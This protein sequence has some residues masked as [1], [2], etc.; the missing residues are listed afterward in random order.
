MDR[1]RPPRPLLPVLGG[2]TAIVVILVGVHLAAPFL[3]PLLFALYFSVL[4]APVH[5]WLQRR[6]LAKGVA[7]LL[8]LALQVAVFGTL[9]VVLSVSLRRFAAQLGTYTLQLE[10][11]LDAL[12]A[13]SAEGALAGLLDSDAF[14]AL[15]GGIVR[16]IISFLGGYFYIQVLM[17]FFIVEGPAI[18]ARL[19]ASL[20]EQHPQV[21]QLP[22]LG[23]T[24]AR[25]F[26]LRAVVNACTGAAIA[27]WL[28]LLGVDYPLLW[29]LLTFFLAYIPYIG[30]V[31]ATVP[32]VV[33]A[34]AE[35][36][37]TRAI[38][39]IVGVA[40]VNLSAENLL[41]PLLLSRGLRISPTAV[42]IAFALWI[43]LLG[44]P[45]AFLAM[46][47]TF[48]L[49]VLFGT[50]P[51]TRWLAAVMTTGTPELPADAGAEGTGTPP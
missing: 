34:F 15:L 12:P 22:E 26:G 16:A 46:P 19:R 36:G 24:I 2:L 37:A 20:G 11:R 39:V 51:G 42:F 30:I 41:S 3:N 33:L 32:S 50:F 7:L 9:F 8:V 27:V 4:L 25:Q 48:F 40:V 6:G 43:W 18:I 14:M 1:S 29:G 21:R 35:Y 47:I 31:V 38:L 13:Q 28:F 23:R 5:A 44:A 17:L 10:S 49:L 45:G